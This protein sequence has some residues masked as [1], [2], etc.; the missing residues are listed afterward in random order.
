M[1]NINEA[2][3]GNHVNAYTPVGKWH[4]LFLLLPLIRGQKYG[5]VLIF[6]YR[7][8]PQ[9]HTHTP[10]IIDTLL[11]DLQSFLTARVQVLLCQGI[12][13]VFAHSIYCMVE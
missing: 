7:I 5:S 13:C 12:T 6:T 1:N 4:C 9:L 10:C 11:R 2:T 3:I 8:S